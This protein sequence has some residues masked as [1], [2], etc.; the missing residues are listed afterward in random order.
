MRTD[1]YYIF[2]FSSQKNERTLNF[3]QMCASSDLF[4]RD[5]IPFHKSINWLL[6]EIFEEEFG[7]IHVLKR[8]SQI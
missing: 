2:N 3:K 7:E 5:K 1:T 4:D 6:L 8:I